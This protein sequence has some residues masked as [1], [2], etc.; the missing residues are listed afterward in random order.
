LA[1]LYLSEGPAEKPNKKLSSWAIDRSNIERHIKPLLGSKLARSLTQAEVARFQSEVAS[2]K[3][4]TDE[5]TGFRGRAIVEGGK[6]T[7]AR[8]LAVLGAMLQFG[9][10]R[11]LLAA[12]PAKGVRLLRGEKRERFLSDAEVASLADALEKT[13]AAHSV[14]RTMAAAIRLLLL[15]GCRKNEILGLRWE[16]V[17]FERGCLRLPDSK[18]GAKVV[19]LAAA[20]LE[21]LAALPRTSAWVLPAAKG[22]GHAVGLQ[23]VWDIVRT[24][25]ALPGFRLHDLRHSFASFAV[26]D[27]HTLFMIGKILGHRQTRTTEVYAHLAADPIKNAADRTGARIVA[28]MKSGTANEKILALSG[29]VEA[30]DPQKVF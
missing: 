18:T 19:P 27:G 3:T 15:T 1:D 20:A 21:I 22:G 25:A 6:G 13:E 29:S 5:K 4:A 7:A 11:G 10:G 26:A 16:W 30:R 9:L 24:H 28:A 8:S 12:N 14:S 2:G 17:D 23:K